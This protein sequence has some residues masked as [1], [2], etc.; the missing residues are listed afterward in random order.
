MGS[1]C[2]FADRTSHPTERF[3]RVS[4]LTS[5][6][7]I[8]DSN[9]I[10]PGRDGVEL[11]QVEKTPVVV[12]GSAELVGSVAV[13]WQGIDE[14]THADGNHWRRNSRSGVCL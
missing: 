5:A 13:S 3:W 6:E 1:S 7:Q 11:I 12:F 2:F 4:L 10:W 9:H 14:E 8:G